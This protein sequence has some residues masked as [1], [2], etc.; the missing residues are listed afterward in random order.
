MVACGESPMVPPAQST[1]PETPAATDPEAQ[2]DVAS[3]RRGAPRVRVP[4]LN[5]VATS[6]ASA[7][8]PG[9]EL[10]TRVHI[11][12]T[13]NANK[14]LLVKHALSGT[15]PHL[16]YYGG[17][18]LG[19]V[20]V[21]TVFWGSG[22]KYQSELNDFYGKVTDSPYFDWLSEY[23]T[24]KQS[25]GR[26]SFGG[27]VV[28]ANAP[29]SSTIDDSAIQ[30]E[31]ASLIHAGK[32]PPSDGNNLYMVHFPPGVTITQGGSQSCQEFC[33]YHGTFNLDGKMTFYGVMP[34]EGGACAT[35]CIDGL[36]QL[37]V[38]TVASS[39]EL[40]EAVTDAGVGLAT[41]NGPPLAWYDQTNGEIGDICAGQAAT[42]SGYSIQLEWSNSHGKCIS[43]SGTV[44][45]P[46]PTGPTGKPGPTGNPGN[47][48]QT[49]AHDACSAGGSLQSSCDPCVAQICAADSYCCSTAW[50][51]TCVGEVVSLCGK[52]CGGN[53]PSGGTTNACTHDLCASG[54]ALAAS[55]D[56]CAAK[57]CASDSYCC[58]T[59]WDS[60]CVNEVSSICGASTCGG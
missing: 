29:K 36:D 44:V 8:E 50:D 11:L 21:W 40:I 37:G 23:N 18:V 19:A 25:I 42:I 48:G 45:P 2:D 3:A 31:L 27:S 46:A 43:S 54:S 60:T 10:G 47:G 35:G 15:T 39:H 56:P 1:P 24:P 59:A 5:S 16:N 58:G 22:V 32:L 14:A 52:T 34:D 49:C 17:P 33:A 57:V 13:Q 55:C 38:T 28:D 51:A 26:G 30:N 20:K 6:S 7:L 4:D 41:T 53:T 12:P 9:L